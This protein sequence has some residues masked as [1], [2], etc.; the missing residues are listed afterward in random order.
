MLRAHAIIQGR[1][2]GVFFRAHTRDEAQRCNLKGWVKNKRDGSV[3]AIFEGREEDVRKMIEWCHKGPPW[4]E[5]IHVHVDWEEYTG[6]FET[7]SVAYRY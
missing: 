3:E 7:F 6:E 2:Q 1:V 5:V 4:A